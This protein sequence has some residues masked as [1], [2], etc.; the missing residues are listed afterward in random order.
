MLAAL[1]AAM[2]WSRWRQLQAWA[3]RAAPLATMM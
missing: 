3:I 1:K 2:R